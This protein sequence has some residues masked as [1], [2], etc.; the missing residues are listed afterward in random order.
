[1]SVKFSLSIDP[2]CFCLNCL[3]C[4]NLV[5]WVLTYHDKMPATDITGGGRGTRQAWHC[6]NC[7]KDCVII[8]NESFCLCNQRLHE[9]RP[10]PEDVSKWM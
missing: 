7:Q 4:C 9:H 1:M 5:E 2:R 8:R 6:T 10:S 3:N